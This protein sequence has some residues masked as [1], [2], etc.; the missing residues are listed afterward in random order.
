MAFLDKAMKGPAFRL[1]LLL[2]V[3]LLLPWQTGSV[4]RENQSATPDNGTF[5]QSKQFQ[6][7]YWFYQRRASRGQRILPGTLRRAARQLERAR[8]L[9]RAAQSQ[10]P[11]QAAVDDAERWVSIGPTPIDVAGRTYYAGRTAAVAVDP[12]DASHWLIGAAQ[13]GIWETADAGKTWESRTDGLE[14]LASGAI[15]FSSS[16][17]GVVYAGTGESTFSGTSYGGLGL[18]K[19]L[20][21]GSSWSFVHRDSFSGRGIS[22]IRIHPDNPDILLVTSVSAVS[23]VPESSSVGIY[24]SQDGGESFVLEKEGQ[25]NDLEVHPGNF[26]LQYSSLSCIFGSEEH[27]GLY[28]SLDQ[29][30]TW[31]MVDGPWADLEGGVGRMETA[32]SP[33]RP[34]RLVVSVQDAITEDPSDGRLLGIWMTDKAWTARPDWVQLPTP[35]TGNTVWYNQQIAFHPG[36]HNFILFGEI[37]LWIFDGSSWSRISPPHVDQH[38]FAWSGERLIVGNDGGV[39]SSLDLGGSWFVH[40]SSLTITQFYLGSLHPSGSEFAIGG[41]QDNG[42][43]AWSGA[44][45][46]DLLVGGDGAASVISPSTPDQ[47]W[48]VSSQRLNIFRTTNGGR[49]FSRAGEG[50]DTSTAPFIAILKGCPFDEDILIAGTDRVWKA[51]DFFDP[52][53]PTWEANSPEL[54][55]GVSALV[56]SPS[57]P[58]CESY[59]VGTFSG[60]LNLTIDGGMS[61]TDVDPFG[62]I[63]ARPVTDLVFD[64]QDSDLLYAAL[65]G[66]DHLS[67]GPFQHV[68]VTRKAFETSPEWHNISPPIDIPVQSLAV[69]PQETDILYAGTDLGLWRSRDRGESWHPITPEQGFPT[70][71]VLDLEVTPEGRT[72]AFTHG[73]GAFLKTE[74]SQVDLSIQLEA[75]PGTAF[76]DEVVNW[77]LRATNNGPGDTQEI[78]VELE[79]QFGHEL[80]QLPDQ[81]VSGKEQ[82]TCHL[83]ELVSGQT[84]LLDVT[85][86]SAQMDLLTAAAS[87]T[88]PAPDPVANND[89]DSLEIQVILPRDEWLIPFFHSSPELE[90]GIAVA[91]LS[92]SDSH[93]LLR[94][95]LE[96]GVPPLPLNPRSYLLRKRRQST[97][98]PR[99]IF[100]EWSDS[101]A[102]WVRIRA[103]SLRLAGFFQVFGRSSLDGAAPA[104]EQFQRAV[105]TRVIQG[106]RGA[107]IRRCVN[108]IGGEYPSGLIKP[109]AERPATEGVH[110]A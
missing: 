66:F 67:E 20:D 70:V 45:R 30:D 37:S 6:R 25:A 15:A 81:C 95:F 39:Y 57:D 60:L 21:G 19:S 43:E 84:V 88:G 28:R 108:S 8:E 2:S 27:E 3:L 16:H 36:N 46:W 14:S 17:P 90:S 35:S 1:R 73:R 7:W 22:E 52:G 41:G 78:E 71:A 107:T 18:L 34:D 59:A 23:P 32:L 51:T 11:G 13:G 26:D 74:A 99:E 53:G 80:E 91:N 61:W 85:T 38:A 94:A 40:N 79:L 48:A 62:L 65:G 55:S 77:Q 109:R 29:G 76:V 47:H 44:N 82:V 75:S 64:P 103:D 106:P 10:M 110:T 89:F 87:I 93:L 104:T 105:F 97:L 24:R 4:A 58:G 31:E 96:E 49:T 83:G 63:P 5:F 101:S 12:G 50:I 9:Q 33:S 42:T 68:F 86:R 98:L 92:D 69:L 100:G 102:G 56:F 54:D 72:M